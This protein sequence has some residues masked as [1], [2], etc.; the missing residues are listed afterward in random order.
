[1]GSRWQVLKRLLLE[2]GDASLEIILYN[3]R[4][5]AVGKRERVLVT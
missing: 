3:G 5:R 4:E 1:M 2:I